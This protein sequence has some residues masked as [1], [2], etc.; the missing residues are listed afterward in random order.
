MS[1][2][3]M[4]EAQ[5]ADWCTPDV[6]LD[7]VRSFFGGK[8]GLDPCGS[9][10][11]HV[12]ARRTYL[13]ERD[14]DG[15][16]LPWQACTYVNPPFDSLREWTAKAAA[17]AKRSEIVFLMPS[18]TDTKAWHDHVAT[19]EAVC[20]W[21][22]RISFL[23]AEGPCPFPIALVFWGARDRIPQFRAHFRGLGMVVTL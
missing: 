23:G 22:G 6:V 4:A 2:G 18:R 14:E 16:S 19:A 11:S 9:K 5:R 10:K 20:F 13:I 12:N 3:Y 8:I 17:E 1:G 15:L 7:P 21:R